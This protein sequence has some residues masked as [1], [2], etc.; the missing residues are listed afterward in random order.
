MKTAL[1]TL[2]LILTIAACMAAL[3]G[4]HGS[5]GLSAFVVPE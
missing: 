1:K 4:C 2:A 5:M 3:S